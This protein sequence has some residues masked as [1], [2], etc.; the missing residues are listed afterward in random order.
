MK[1]ILWFALAVCLAVNTFAEDQKATSPGL[2]IESALYGTD[3]NRIDVADVLRPLIAHDCLFLRA[4]WGLGDRDPAP[5]VKKDVRIVFSFHGTHQ[6]ASFTQDQDILL[7]PAPSAFT[8]LSANFGA[9]SRRV[10]VTDAVRAEVKDGSLHKWQHWGFGRIDPAFGI[11]KTVEIVYAEGGVLKT[12]T[13]HQHQEI[14]LP[15]SES[16][17]VP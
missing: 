13:F 7:L 10:D 2:I 14:N 3:E 4:K 11:V 5:G 9:D 16:T 12:A 1:A 15:R 8:I 17:E 6:L